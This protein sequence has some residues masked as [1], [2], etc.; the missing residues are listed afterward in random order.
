[1]VSLVEDGAA[2]ACGEIQIGDI[3]MAIDDT[4]VEVLPMSYVKPLL[5][6]HVGSKVIMLTSLSPRIREHRSITGTGMH[7]SIPP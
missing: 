4:Q 6:G 1:M 2:R 5:L 3:L 7:A